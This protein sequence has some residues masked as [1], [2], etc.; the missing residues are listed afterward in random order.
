MEQAHSSTAKHVRAFDRLFFRDTPFETWPI[1]DAESVSN[2]SSRDASNFH[3]LYQ[4]CRALVV[5]TGPADY[6]TVLTEAKRHYPNLDARLLTYG[7]TAGFSRLT[8]NV[9]PFP[10][11]ARDMKIASGAF[12]FLAVHDQHVSLPRL[13]YRVLWSLPGTETESLNLR[14]VIG[15]FI[16]SR[17]PGSLALILFEAGSVIEY[18]SSTDLMAAGNLL[19]TVEV[20]IRNEEGTEATLRTIQDYFRS[21]ADLSLNEDAFARVKRRQIS[22]V[23]EGTLDPVAMMAQLGADTILCGFLAAS[24]QIERL[25]KMTFAEYRRFSNAMSSPLREGALLFAP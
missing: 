3:G 15:E 25:E 9:E 11:N 13:V 14:S 2:L 5:A 8:N 22:Q 21:I 1:G 10:P 23:T 24:S 6:D 16:A 18:S 20:T 17:L 7:I 19:V 12:S 4:T